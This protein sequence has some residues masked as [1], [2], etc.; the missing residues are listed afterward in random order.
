MSA[1]C[2]AA[3]IRGM[4]GPRGQV[5]ESLSQ[6]PVAQ[7]AESADSFDLNQP[8]DVCQHLTDRVEAE[9]TATHNLRGSNGRFL[10]RAHGK[11]LGGNGCAR[12]PSPPQLFLSCGVVTPLYYRRCSRKASRSRNSC[13]VIKAAK[14][15]GMTDVRNARRSSTSGRGMIS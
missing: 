10:C 8:I 11:L 3:P 15:F 13:T 9:A 12:G 4:V 7:A 6:S 5:I 14:S 2:W 1:A